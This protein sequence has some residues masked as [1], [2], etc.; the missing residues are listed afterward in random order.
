M[1]ITAN[2]W[3][4]KNVQLHLVPLAALESLQNSDIQETRNLLSPLIVPTSD[5]TS[6]PNVGTWRRRYLQV[7]ND[8]TDALWVTRLVV[9][10]ET[11]EIIGRAGFHGKP[12]ERG[13]VEIGYAIDPLYRRKGYG[14]EVARIMVDVARGDPN[15]KVVRASVAPHNLVSRRIVVGFGFEKV[16]EEMDEEDGLEEVFELA[17]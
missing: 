10:R 12:D 7:L 15:V 1:A 4:D 8:P 17:V 9:V 11:R 5:L 16:G 2:P 3:G 14:R 6:P 13:M